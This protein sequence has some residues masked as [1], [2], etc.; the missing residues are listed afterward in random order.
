MTGVK[1]PRLRSQEKRM[2]E[3]IFAP[4]GGEEA[5]CEKAY[6]L[7]VFGA[8]GFT[9]K[10]V[11]LHV[12]QHG[13]SGLRWA[14]GGRD[15]GKLEKLRRDLVDCR[16]AIPPAG[17]VVGDLRDVKDCC[18]IAETAKCVL[19]TCGP[20]DQYGR[21]LVK[22]C[23]NV[24]TN[25]VDITGEA[26]PFVRDS[27]DLDAI[28]KKTGAT[29]AHCCGFDSVP[30]DLLAKLAIEAIEARG[31]RC[32]KCVVAL[33]APE[34][35][36]GFSGGTIASGI[37][38]MR[39]VLK[40]PKDFFAS[41]DQDVLCPQVKTPS[42]PS[43]FSFSRDLLNVGSFWWLLLPGYD[44]LLGAWHAPFVMAWCNQKVVRLSCALRKET[45]TE[46]KEVMTPLPLGGGNWGVVGLVVAVVTWLSFN[47]LTTILFVVPSTWLPRP[48]TG[49]SRKERLGGSWSLRVAARGDTSKVV[50]RVVAQGQDPGYGS[51]AAMAAECALSLVSDG[52]P[53]G[54]VSPS[55]ACPGLPARL[56]AFGITFSLK[57]D[58]DDKKRRQVVSSLR[59]EDDSLPRGR[60]L[61]RLPLHPPRRARL[62]L[63]GLPRCHR[64]LLP[65]GPRRIRGLR[66]LLLFR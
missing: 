50:G 8:S 11:A 19:T 16:Y 61:R 66:L 47:L 27:L 9:G 42:S 40:H 28:A 32:Q 1:A 13:P 21:E 3:T 54:L 52:A 7:V 38:I 26:V 43:K 46:Y 31:E 18:R 51:T 57:V 35:M 34:C 58:D 56:K 33:E 30:S 48:G 6:A 14:L 15:K 10:L 37:G 24:G 2:F 45:T 39:H 55:V 49:P 29:I 36:G 62:R 65:R 4:G 53:A 60:R 17:I 23:A 25:Y 5:K 22:A 41:L 63:S 20:Y 44:S 59:P 64:R 12:A